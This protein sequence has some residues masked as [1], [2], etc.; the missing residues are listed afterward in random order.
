MELHMKQILVQISDGMAAELEK[1][2]PGRGRKRSAFVREAI[3]RAIM[4]AMEARTREAYERW[5][6]EPVG[7][8]PDAWAPE[9]EAIHPPPGHPL[10]RRRKRR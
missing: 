5:P 1:I 6:Q 10:A 8:D 2:A 9:A 3:A 4:D 7:F